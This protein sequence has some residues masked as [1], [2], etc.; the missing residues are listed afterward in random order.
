LQKTQKNKGEIKLFT[1]FGG[2]GDGP[3][4]PPPCIRA[5]LVEYFMR[6]KLLSLS[7]EKQYGDKKSPINNSC[8]R[9]WHKI[10]QGIFCPFA[11]FAEA[12]D[13]HQAVCLSNLLS[14]RPEEP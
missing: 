6:I 13:P 14:S 4:G 2:G 12:L 8:Y 10:F 3:K 7:E 1:I 11:Y 5:G 9:W